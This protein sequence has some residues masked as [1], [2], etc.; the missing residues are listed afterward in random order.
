MS[1]S[2]R[3]YLSDP[4]LGLLWRRI[5]EA[6]PIRSVSL[7]ITH[8]CNLRC[9]GCYYFSEGM[10]RFR[11]AQAEAALDRWI[12]QEKERGTNFVTVVGGEPSLVL[13]RLEKLYAHFR[14]SVAT[15]GLR[16]IPME[17]FEDLPI[18]ISL[19]G[20]PQTDRLLRGSGKIDVFAKA[21]KN[22][23]NDARAFWYYTVA[24]GLAHEVETV[25]ARCLDNGNRI[26]FNYYSDLMGQGGVLDYRQGFDRVRE[27][28]DRLIERYPGQLLTTSWFNQVVTTGELLGQRWGYDV[29]TNVSNN[30]LPNAARLENGQPYNRHFRAYNADFETVRR[31]CTGIDRDCA[32]CFDTWEHF[33]WIMIHM[34]KHMANVALFT[35][36]LTTM[37]MF[38]FI[39]RLVPQDEGAALLPELQRRVRQA[40]LALQPAKASC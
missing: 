25:V 35:C 38:Y 10:D 5:R 39:T 1:G 15:N 37:Y 3:A 26:L 4:F 16:K 32:S 33:S 7:D 14:L 23:R 27:V 29:C 34:K 2:L 30:Y 18:G 20:S 17:G 21:L 9:T 28:I 19:W 13:H 8:R 40:M 24:P 12:A 36:W 6:G 11:S 22:Y 31:C